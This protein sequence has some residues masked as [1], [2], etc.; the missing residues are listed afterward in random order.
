MQ[1]L[2]NHNK[3]TGKRVETMQSKGVVPAARRASKK[4][5]SS[6]RKKAPQQIGQVGPPGDL[7]TPSTVGSDVGTKSLD[8]DLA[9]IRVQDPSPDVR[10]QLEK[11]FESL[12][13]PQATTIVL[14]AD[15]AQSVFD[16][17]QSLFHT[18]KRPADFDRGFS[19]LLIT[20][21]LRKL[22]H[23]QEAWFKFWN[24]RTGLEIMDE[25][26]M[27]ETHRNE[28]R[29]LQHC[30]FH[31]DM[32]DTI[33]PPA[34]PGLRGQAEDSRASKAR[35]FVEALRLFTAFKTTDDY[36]PALIEQTKS[37][38]NIAPHVIWHYLYFWI[39]HSHERSD[40]F[41]LAFHTT[42]TGKRNVAFKTFF[43]AV[44]KFSAEELDHRLARSPSAPSQIQQI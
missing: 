21:M 27:G 2:T 31:V 9:A 4:N 20:G 13:P 44:F 35:V 15:Q 8:F 25:A 12:V 19:K 34:G 14:R 3:S 36:K 16:R 11:L 37:F 42:P 22:H 7:K 1:R 41:R 18:A 10:A 38:V 29:V 40:L 23:N 43:N 26:T 32:I 5:V 17:V 33:I 24:R 28:R 6:R 30:L 39:E